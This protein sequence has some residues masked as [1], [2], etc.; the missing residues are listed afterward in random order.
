MLIF[1]VNAFQF[2]SLS[3][4]RPHTKMSNWTVFNA[5]NLSNIPDLLH[6]ACLPSLGNAQAGGGGG[7]GGVAYLL[8]VFCLFFG[9]NKIYSFIVI[10]S[11]TNKYRK[12]KS[13]MLIGVLF[14]FF[15]LRVLFIYIDGGVG[16]DIYMSN[17]V[18]SSLSRE[19]PVTV[20]VY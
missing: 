15:L 1:V 10:I 18:F 16:I 8:H 6:S 11:S 3:V 2:Y 4:L 19:V 20:F 17:H 12:R 5:W 14:I 7:G 9:L 13:T